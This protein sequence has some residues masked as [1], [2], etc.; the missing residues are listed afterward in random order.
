MSINKREGF[1]SLNCSFSIHKNGKRAYVLYDEN[2]GMY[3]IFKVVDEG[4]G[5]R[6]AIV[7]IDFNL[8]SALDNAKEFVE[9]TL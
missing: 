9:E 6:P 2:P 3:F 8:E 1:K 5:G 7:D 4:G